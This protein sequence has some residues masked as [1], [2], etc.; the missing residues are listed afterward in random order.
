M[1]R[2][3]PQS[4][5]ALLMSRDF[6]SLIDQNDVIVLESVFRLGVPV[7]WVH[8]SLGRLHSPPVAMERE[9]AKAD[10]QHVVCS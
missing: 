8:D 6:E 10:S 9:W 7:R 2:G 4:N 1:G 5:S 3:K